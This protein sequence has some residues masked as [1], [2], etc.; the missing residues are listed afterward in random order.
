MKLLKVKA[1]LIPENEYEEVAFLPPRAKPVTGPL[2]V[3]DFVE[4]SPHGYIREKYRIPVDD[5]GVRRTG[6]C[7][8][9]FS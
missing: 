3:G 6:L 9:L 2:Q 7:P 4:M 8:D 1:V 5:H